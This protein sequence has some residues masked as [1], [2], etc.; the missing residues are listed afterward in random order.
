MAAAAL[1]EGFSLAKMEMLN[2]ETVTSCGKKVSG[3][4]KLTVQVGTTGVYFENLVLLLLVVG[5][6]PLPFNLGPNGPNPLC[7]CAALLCLS[8]E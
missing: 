1:E 2:S 7:D 6:M 3:G 4:K 5:L 8:V